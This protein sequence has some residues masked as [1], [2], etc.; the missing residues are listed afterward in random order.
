MQTFI[1]LVL[2]LRVLS[3]YD[4]AF[5]YQVF[6]LYECSLLTHTEVVSSQLDA[7]RK[8]LDISEKK[9]DISEATVAKLQNNPI[10]VFLDGGPFL[11]YGYE[12]NGKI[13]FGT[14]FRNK[15]GQ[16][17]K[18]HKTSVPDLAIGFV[19]YA[20]KAN[21]QELNCVIKKRFKVSRNTEHVDCSISDM[22]TFVFSYLD[23]MNC[24]YK[25][26]DVHTL[27]LLNIFLKS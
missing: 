19:V 24:E 8:Q 9:L 3:D 25:K 10:D 21:L 26:E 7:C 20:S 1:G 4:I 12:C 6:K 17:P 27:K 15:N 13:K 22:E 18:S 11:L 2:A 23:L 16:R 5:S 14:S